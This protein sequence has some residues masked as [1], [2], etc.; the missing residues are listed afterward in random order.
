MPVSKKRKKPMKKAPS[1]RAAPAQA[2]NPFKLAMR[3][4]DNGV[5]VGRPVVGDEV[6]ERYFHQLSIEEQL[7]Y[8]DVVMASGDVMADGDGVTD[9]YLEYDDG[10]LRPFFQILLLDSGAADDFC[11]ICIERPDIW[12][13]RRFKAAPCEPLRPAEA[14]LAMAI[15]LEEIIAAGLVIDEGYEDEGGIVSTYVYRAARLVAVAGYDLDERDIIEAGHS[16]GA[17]EDM[18]GRAM[19][20]VHEAR[21]QTEVAGAGAETEA[22]EAPVRQIPGPSL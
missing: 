19:A 2:Q 1:T 13:N 7:S 17:V 14:L 20:I 22:G 12:K 10:S 16:P 5:V 4:D 9:F 6:W 15:Q 21:L 18:A 3:V 11:R 8:Y